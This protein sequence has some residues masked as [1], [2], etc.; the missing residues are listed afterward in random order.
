MLLLIYIQPGK[1][2]QF[3]HIVY[4]N[5]ITGQEKHYIINIVLQKI[6]QRLYSMPY[7]AV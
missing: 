2:F 3:Q 6:K 1:I 4:K 7:N 5:R